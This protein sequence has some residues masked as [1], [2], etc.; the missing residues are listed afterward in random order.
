M[1]FKSHRY[2]ENNFNYENLFLQNFDTKLINDLLYR[3][4]PESPNLIINVYEYVLTNAICSSIID[5]DIDSI[6]ID[7]LGYELLRFKLIEKSEDEIRDIIYTHT[8]NIINKLELSDNVSNYIY[9]TLPN[10]ELSIITS[11]YNDSLNNLLE[12]IYN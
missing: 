2:E 7:T 10:I 11:V 4:S 6:Y 1:H 8:R 5:Y 9:K 12:R 3:I